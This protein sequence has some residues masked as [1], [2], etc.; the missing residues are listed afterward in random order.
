MFFRI[1][2]FH[3]P[4]FGWFLGN[5]EILCFGSF[6]ALWEAIQKWFNRGPDSE[7]SKN[8]KSLK[9][10]PYDPKWWKKLKNMFLHCLEQV[11]M[12]FEAFEK[13]DSLITSLKFW[14]WLAVGVGG[15]SFDVE[16]KWPLAE[17]QKIKTIF[18]SK[19][20]KRY[21]HP[22]NLK[23]YLHPIMPLFF[24]IIGDTMPRFRFSRSHKKK[25]IKV[26]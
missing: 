11:W 20:S 6:L 5:L 15:F 2:H 17:I 19:K 8:S 7:K 21:L 14:G 22:K 16:L 26:F 4:V 1:Y 10:D 18:T 3:L 13:F 12:N 25:Q 9:N 23:I 24:F